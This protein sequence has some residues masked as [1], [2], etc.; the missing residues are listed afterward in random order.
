MVHGNEA[1]PSVE[2]AELVVQW[3]DQM[4]T[5]LTMRLMVSEAHPLHDLIVA[6]LTKAA[7]TYRAEQDENG[8]EPPASE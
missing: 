8:D 3:A 7:E 5:Q 2:E 6:G 4:M 1:D